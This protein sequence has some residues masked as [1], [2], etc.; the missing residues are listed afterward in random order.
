MLLCIQALQG[1]CGPEDRDALALVPPVAE[2]Q[3]HVTTTLRRSDLYACS[4][5]PGKNVA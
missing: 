1:V 2:L 3:Q 4:P 5:A